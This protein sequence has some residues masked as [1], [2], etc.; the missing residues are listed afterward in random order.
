MNIETRVR[1]LG[2][3]LEVSVDGVLGSGPEGVSDHGTEVVQGVRVVGQPDNRTVFHLPPTLV[4]S[5]WSRSVEAWLSLVKSFNVL[6]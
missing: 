1:A 3:G 5:H 2:Q 6:K 4:H